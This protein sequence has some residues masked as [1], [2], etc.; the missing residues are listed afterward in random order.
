MTLSFPSSMILSSSISA[1]YIL[2]YLNNTN[3]TSTTLAPTSIVSGTNTIITLNFSNLVTSDISAG[4][5]FTITINSIK[6][7]KSFKTIYPQLTSY[8]NDGYGIEQSGLTDFPLTNTI[9]DT[10]LIVASTTTIRI[11][12]QPTNV[13]FQITPTSSLNV[14][15]IITVQL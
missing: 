15:D 6:N 8:T 9:Q 13:S 7:Y 1:S 2:T 14:G 12:G 11:N 10:S 4:N 5:I 3:S